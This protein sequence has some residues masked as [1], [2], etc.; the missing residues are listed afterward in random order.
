MK[1]LVLIVSIFLGC[2]LASPAQKSKVI[3][4]FQLIETGKYD[5]AKEAIEEA[6]S[7]KKTGQWPRTW[8]ARGLLCQTAYQKGIAENDQKKY[9]LYP[10]QLYQAFND[11]EKAR[12]LDDR[13]R[14]DGQLA[15]KYVILANDFEDLGVKHYRKGEYGEALKAFERAIQIYRSPILPVRVDTN[16]IYNAALAAFENEAWEKAIGYLEKLD[17]DNYSP[18]VPHLLS[19]IYLGKADTAAAEK[20]LMEGIGRYEDNEDLILLL[21]D[22]LFQKNDTVRAMELLDSASSTDSSNYIFPY[23]KG[24]LYQKS[25]QYKEAIDAYEEALSLAPGEPKIYANI[26]TCHYNMGVEIER[27]A[28][29]ITSNRAYLREKEKS[30]KAFGTAVSWFEKAL[31]KNPDNQYVI[32]K[33]H[34]LYEVLGIS[35][36]KKKMEELMN[37]SPRN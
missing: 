24:L 37:S 7:D 26:G 5:E 36:K 10:D 31:D 34:Q 18:N 23:T 30:A 13:G 6:I 8:Y 35:D 3:A 2:Y 27:N 25:E 12:S 17:K 11:Y 28:T 1:R 16:L 22:L 14:L 32:T 21:V 20:V 33:L 15:P 4:V 19:T 9:G 29:A